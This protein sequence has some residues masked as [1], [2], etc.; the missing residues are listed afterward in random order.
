MKTQLANMTIIE[1]VRTAQNY[2]NSIQQNETYSAIITEMGCRLEALN[3]AHIGAMNTVRNS[4]SMIDKLAAENAYLINGAARELNTSWMFHKTMLGAQAALVCVAQGDIRA[5][6]DW[7]EGTTDEAG[8]DI[9]DE[10]TAPEL[11]AWFA[12]Q[13]ISNDG[14]SGFLTHKQAEEA[15]RAKCPVTEAF[16]AE[17]R[18]QGVEMFV[19]KIASALRTAGGGDGYHEEPY[20]EFA[21]HLESKGEDFADQLRQGG[22]A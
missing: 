21:D 5:T 7:L 4:T 19:A 1:L 10:I 15:I 8:A 17:V 2:A 11:Q 14:K 9:P 18:A 6:R 13:M 20:H 3:L 12:S 22:S 16:L